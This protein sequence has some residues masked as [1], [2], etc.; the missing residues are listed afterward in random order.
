MLAKIGSPQ[1]ITNHQNNVPPCLATQTLQ[2]PCSCQV[3][4]VVSVVVF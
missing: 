3:S 4:V 1:T 2:D